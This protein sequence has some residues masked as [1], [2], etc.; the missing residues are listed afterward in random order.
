MENVMQTFADFKRLAQVGA[1]FERTFMGNPPKGQEATAIRTVNH[2]QS[3]AIAFRADESNS[4]SEPSNRAWFYFPK[5]GAYRLENGL[6]IL[7][8]IYGNPRMSLRPIHAAVA[9]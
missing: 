1:Q 6:L 9:A 2:V 4:S 8:D 5:A 7:L 3:N